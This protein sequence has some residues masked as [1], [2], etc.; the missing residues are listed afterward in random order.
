MSLE[1]ELLQ[2]LRFDLHVEHPYTYLLQYGKAFKMEKEKMNVILTNAWTFINDCN[3]TT[4]CLQWE[5]EVFGLHSN[6]SHVITKNQHLFLR[7]LLLMGEWV[8]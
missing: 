5:P 3:C 4:L 7:G 8:I 1:R 2:T 6:K